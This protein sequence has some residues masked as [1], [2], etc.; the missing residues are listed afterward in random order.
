MNSNEMKSAIQEDIETLKTIDVDIMSPKAY[1]GAIRRLYFSVCLKMYASL[2]IPCVLA[3]LL[4]SRGIIPHDAEVFGYATLAWI[5]AIPGTIILSIPLFGLITNYVIF[6]AQFKD[7]LRLGEDIDQMIRRMGRLAWFSFW[8][9]MSLATVAF[10]PFM[11][12]MLGVFGGGIILW[13]IGMFVEMEVKRLGISVLFETLKKHFDDKDSAS[14]D[15]NSTT[16][17]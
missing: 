16:I 14:T 2:I 17:N 7:K 10:H 4:D 9:V 5:A 13:G 6:K 3:Y 11:L 8:C 15:P 12:L 1:Y